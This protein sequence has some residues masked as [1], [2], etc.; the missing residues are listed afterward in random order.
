MLNKEEIGNLKIGDTLKFFSLREK[1][2]VKGI[3]KK[4]N[5]RTVILE[6]KNNRTKTIKEKDLLGKIIAKILK[7][8]ELKLIKKTYQA[9]KL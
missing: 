5:K 7:I 6:V 8:G 3:L 4:K 1:K 9:V 2:E